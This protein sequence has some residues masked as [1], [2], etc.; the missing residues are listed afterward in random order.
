MIL[1]CKVTKG[2]NLPKKKGCE[3]V[4]EVGYAVIQRD[5]GGRTM[6]SSYFL[7]AS[8]HSRGRT[9]G[10][11]KDISEINFKINN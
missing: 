6:Y 10:I 4:S 5:G 2:L 11:A 7:L 1:I 8:L 9:S 3:D